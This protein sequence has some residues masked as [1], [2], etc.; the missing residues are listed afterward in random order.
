FENVV[1]L[2][3]LIHAGQLV[4]SDGQ[5]PAGPAGHL[6]SGAE[7]HQRFVEIERDNRRDRVELG[8]QADLLSGA[9]ELLGD[10]ESDRGAE[11]VTAEQVWS[12]R[13]HLLHRGD[14]CGRTRFDGAVVVFTAG[15]VSEFGRL[16]RVERLFWSKQARELV[17]AEYLSAGR[18]HT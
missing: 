15:D 5:T 3:L 13:L 11:G 6:T 14:V 2:F 17:V 16:P 10:L 7:K 8:Q 1:E 18:M 9:S 12:N 4:G